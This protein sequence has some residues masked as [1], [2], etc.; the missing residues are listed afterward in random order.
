MRTPKWRRGSIDVWQQ[1][2]DTPRMLRLGRR[3]KIFLSLVCILV[4]GMRITGAHLHLCFDGSE[5]PASVHFGNDR[6]L[7]H[8]LG[9]H[10]DATVEHADVDV[11]L[12]SDALFKSSSTSFDLLDLFGALAWL[13]GCFVF[14][15][16]A[17]FLFESFVPIDTT[18]A[19]LR[20][21][22]RGPPR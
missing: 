8:L 6:G 9:E 10:E 13:L 17:V 5:P 7:H 22:L 18:R 12:V 15:R 19:Y 16:Q 3:S 4:V 20:P 14:V 1:A 11:N 2:R 21:P